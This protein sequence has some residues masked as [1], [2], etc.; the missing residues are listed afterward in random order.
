LSREVTT[1][2]V[3]SLLQFE[4]RKLRQLSGTFTAPSL[5]EAVQ[6]GLGLMLAAALAPHR[7]R[8]VARP[9]CGP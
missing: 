1:K 3:R 9:Q 2:S 4:Q 7:R 6:V 5:H 8:D